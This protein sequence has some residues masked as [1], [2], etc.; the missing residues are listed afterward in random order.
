MGKVKE[1]PEAKLIAG[2]LLSHEL[3]WERVVR[4]LEVEQGPIDSKSEP[5]SFTHT[6]YYTAELGSPIERFWVSFEW[7]AEQDELPDLKH[8]TNKLE[9]ILGRSDGSRR[10]NIDPGIITGSRLVLATTKDHAHR[11][12]L[13]NGIYA[14]VTLIYRD[15]KFNPL[16]WTYPDY[17]EQVA[18]DYFSAVR[19]RYLQQLRGGASNS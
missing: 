12:Y 14:E 11:I 3:S 7:L 13:S 8:E 19:T 5:F 9:E 10:V 17:R 1:P 15:G 2:I 4:Q 18:L 16:P 6:D